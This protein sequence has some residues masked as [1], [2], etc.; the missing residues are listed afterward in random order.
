MPCQV[1]LASEEVDRDSSLASRLMDMYQRLG[2]DLAIQ[3]GGSTAHN[4]IFQRERG[5][6]RAAAQSQDF[7]TSLK[8]FYSNTYTDQDKQA[9][10]N[11]FLGNF[12]PETGK[13]TLW[14]LDTDYYLHAAK[15][16]DA[17]GQ[18]RSSS[19]LNVKENQSS[20][21]ASDSFHFRVE[22]GLS[23]REAARIDKLT[24]FDKVLGTSC[25]MCLNVS[26]GKE[27][28]LSTPV[29][30]T[31]TPSVWLSAVAQ[32]Q[33]AVAGAPE[34][35][36]G[37]DV[38]SVNE[39]VSIGDADSSGL[40]SDEQ[41]LAFYQSP[42]EFFDERW[43]SGQG[44]TAGAP[45]DCANDTPDLLSHITSRHIKAQLQTIA[46]LPLLRAMSLAS[47]P[48]D[49]LCLDATKGENSEYENFNIDRIGKDL[50]S[51]I[52]SSREG[53]WEV[54]K[55]GLESLEM[56]HTASLNWSNALEAMVIGLQDAR[57]LAQAPT[58]ANDR[59]QSMGRST[60]GITGLRDAHEQTLKELCSLKSL[61]CM[62]PVLKP[63][64]G[65]PTA[66]QM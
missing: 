63:G 22:D 18:E 62:S 15:A 17:T 33:A 36:S 52:L 19:K 41:C 60:D 42:I 23:K 37:Q 50:M 53:S 21:P 40:T 14:D 61:V 8:R 6:S 32:H 38:E 26:I 7:L 59:V 16:N 58:S 44:S 25:N 56:V 57:P 3:Y 13:P 48:L 65:D 27:A 47:A 1:G 43:F 29:D 64:Q 5:A 9:A 34:Q 31:E 46:S 24:V 51:S 2:D 49:E 45:P 39:S 12:W 35:D 54:S 11:L 10:L 30:P 4:T 20:P 55:L 28:V 66:V